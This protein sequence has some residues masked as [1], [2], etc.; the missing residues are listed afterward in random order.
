MYDD[1]DD[2]DDIY[3]DDIEFVPTHE[4]ETPLGVEPV[5]LCIGGS[6]YTEAEWRS[7][8]RADYEFSRKHGWTFQGQ[9][10]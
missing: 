6:A 3:Y 7:D 2:D 8:S 5:R 1:Y 4:I 9:P 10:F